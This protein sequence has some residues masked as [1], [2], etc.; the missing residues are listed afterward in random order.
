[1]RIDRKLH[2]I[3]PIYDDGDD[4]QIIA[5]V[6]STP[7]GEQTIDQYFLVLGQTYSM[8]FGEQLGIYAGPGHAMRI[9]KYVANQR[10]MWF[11]ANGVL[12]VER[13]LVAEIRRLTMVAALKGGKWE[14]LP[15]EIA[16]QQG[17]IN[18]D[19]LEGVEN[20]IVFFI[21]ACAT[22]PRVQRAAMVQ[23]AAGL[24]GAQVTSSPFTEWS[25][26]LKT[27]TA[28]GNSGAKS[29][30]T[31]KDEPTPVAVPLA[32]KRSSVPF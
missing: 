25:N 6:H 28:T 9:L 10:G 19:D 22:L 4:S 5:Y 2:L 23:A 20:A 7:L 29:H 32:V 21:A 11:D 13:G 26:S 3:V 27:S 8:M 18:R 14:H 17:I 31:V 16:T 24:W 12:G 1:M 30:A 15:L